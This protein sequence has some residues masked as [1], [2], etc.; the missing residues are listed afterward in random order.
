MKKCPTCNKTFED[1]FRFCQTDGTPLVDDAPAL[2]PYATIVQSHVVAAPTET[3]AETTPAEEAEL[4][5]PIHQTVGS[6]PISEPED[7]LDLP[8]ADPLKTMVVSD[9]EMQAA[10]SG[11]IPASDLAPE[12]PPVETEPEAPLAEET[13]TP[14][15]PSFS[16]P[17]IPAP[18]FADAAPPPS[19]FSHSESPNGDPSPT[20]PSFEDK[21][22]APDSEELFPANAP[23]DEMATL[24]Q[25][26]VSTPIETPSAPSETPPA[27]VSGGWEPPPA[28]VAAWENQEIGSNT[29]LQPPPAGTGGGQSKTLAIISLVT[30]ILSFLCCSSIFVVGIA[31]IITGFMAKSKA[32][33]NPDEYG[34]SG[35]ALAGMILGGI[36]LVF[37]ILYWILMLTGMIKLPSF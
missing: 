29:P 6:M 8:E 32:N 2:D 36:S 35:L 19:P 4:E 5:P 12:S 16:V 34:G 1:S 30:G 33:S 15:P 23:K 28:P 25:P 10:L 21:V 13:P 24:I 14:E 31:A 20:S 37:G 22:S 7:V 11:E 3:P 26:A 27:A 9:A 17:D 18:S